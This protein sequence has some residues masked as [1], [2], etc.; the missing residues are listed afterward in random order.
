MYIC[1]H[2]AS[3]KKCR[4]RVKLIHFLLLFV[5]TIW[6]SPTN[7]QTWFTTTGSTNEAKLLRQITLSGRLPEHFTPEV[8]PWPVNH[9][10]SWLDSLKPSN[11]N[12]INR[13]NRQWLKNENAYTT[14]S[15][16]QN[17]GNNP[18]KSRLW[19]PN[20]ARFFESG[21]QQ[22]YLT[23]NPGINL[24]IGTSRKEELPLFVNHRMIEF[25]GHIAGKLGFYSRV[26]ETQLRGALHEQAFFSK[27][28]ILPGVHL[29][30]PYRTRGYDY[31][32]ATSY[33]TYSPINEIMIQFGQD[34]NF[35]G[36]GIRSLLLSDFAT[37]YPFLKIHTRVGRFDY[38]NLYARLTDR[39]SRLVNPS[40]HILLPAK[41][42]AMHYLAFRI[43]PKW[44][45][46]IFE[47]VM[48]HD[49]NNTGKGFDVAYLNPVILYRAIEHQRG[50]PD[51]MT[52]GFN[53][54]YLAMPGVELYGQFLLNEFRFYDLVKGTG[55]HANKYGW[56]AG[57]RL[58]TDQILQGF[59]LQTEIN[60]IRPYTYAH[61]TVSGTYPVNS[62]SHQN[63]PLAHPLGANLREWL[64]KAG[65]Q[66]WPKFSTGLMAQYVL[67]GA[68]SAGS[69]WGGN[70]FLDYRT[71]ER[72]KGNVIGQGVATHLLNLNAWLSY[73]IRHGI[74]ISLE[75]RLRRLRSDI[76]ARNSTD[77]FLGGSI[78]YNLPQTYWHY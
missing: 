55:S 74:S 45:A 20:P 31:L 24:S 67:F 47:A 35:I 52:A 25:K 40:Q 4:Y 77:A 56:Q 71:Y 28:G 7:S 43:S 29:V 51:K 16:Q 68:D 64:L 42:Y 75:A 10:S 30:K 54:Q 63:Q 12:R 44:R 48:F 19:S 36:N 41:Y 34:H 38:V 11:N 59:E 50:D 9:V 70:I 5:S 8:R 58:A 27:W 72:E 15:L 78:R 73:E 22:F 32:T 14:L 23:I 26:N 2:A 49:N 3:V 65:F 18:P 60:C 33:I 69:N 57:V 61:Y 13:Y 17:G 1:Q 66:P 62:Y 39:Y 76:V 37:A 53:T 6:A 46:G 21:T